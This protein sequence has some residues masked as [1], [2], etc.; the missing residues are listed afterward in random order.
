M[1][2]VRDRK[3]ESSGNRVNGLWAS[4]PKIESLYF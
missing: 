3:R 2:K 4:L 1:S